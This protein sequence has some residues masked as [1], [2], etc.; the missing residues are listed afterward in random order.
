M[1]NLGVVMDDRGRGNIDEK[2]EWK[3]DAILRL[4]YLLI[5]EFEIIKGSNEQVKI[6]VKRENLSISAV[7]K[8]KDTY[9]KTHLNPSGTSKI[10]AY[11]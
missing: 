4:S 9:S 10:L 5:Y 7:H 3:E 8:I 2:N 6:T 11:C 1:I